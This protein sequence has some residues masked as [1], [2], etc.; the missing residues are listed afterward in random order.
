MRFLLNPS[1][2]HT[3]S[4][5]EYCTYRFMGTWVQTWKMVWSD[6]VL[7]SILI[8]FIDYGS[9][10]LFYFLN[11][12]SFRFTMSG[13]CTRSVYTR[14]FTI[15]LFRFQPRGMDLTRNMVLLPRTD[16]CLG[17]M[18]LYNSDGG[19]YINTWGEKI[20]RSLNIFLQRCQSPHLFIWHSSRIHILM[21]NRQ[22]RWQWKDS[23]LSLNSLWTPMIP[24]R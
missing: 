19:D 18:A 4:S 8:R 24:S 9:V 5:M 23:W 10:F 16:S 2:F 3:E 20:S 17:F 1:R 11:L 21:S 14:W 22:S 7:F 13:P 6:I 15:G 12:V